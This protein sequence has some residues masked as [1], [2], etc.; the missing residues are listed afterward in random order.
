[1]SVN[2]RVLPS[3]VSSNPDQDDVLVLASTHA[4]SLSRELS[5]NLTLFQLDT[6]PFLGW[7][8]H[9]ALPD[10]TFAQIQANR[11]L[12]FIGTSPHNRRTLVLM[13][14][15]NQRLSWFGQ[16]LTGNHLLVLPPHTRLF[17]VTPAN[18]E[19][20]FISVDERAMAQTLPRNTQSSVQ[21]ALLA[22]EPQMIEVPDLDHVRRQ[23][24]FLLEDVLAPL[25]TATTTPPRTRRR[26]DRAL[27]QAHSLIQE[28]PGDALTI[29]DLCDAG[30]VSERTLQYAFI[31]HFGLNPKRYFVVHRLN[32]ARNDILR[33]GPNRIKISE[34]AIRHGFWHMGRFAADY[35][36][37]FGELPSR[38]LKRAPRQLSEPCLKAPRFY[39][40]QDLGTRD[41][42]PSGTSGL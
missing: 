15:G 4:Q 37:L 28:C 14:D 38:T 13:A 16:Q 10:S 26:R 39:A 3:T 19:V 8:K 36:T 6:G 40:H 30:Q 2:M 32:R 31:E 27:I 7:M 20:L 5:G 23:N 11:S 21:Q 9:L 35:K 33:F 42:I 22:N 18:H 12:E 24:P 29:Q 1:M 41:T 34:A 25:A 17:A